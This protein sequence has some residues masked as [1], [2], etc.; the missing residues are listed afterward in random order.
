VGTHGYDVLVPNPGVNSFNSGT[1]PFGNLPTAPIDARFSQVSQLNSNGVSNFAGLITS[2]TR[3]FG[4][5]FQGSLN[6][7]YSHALD[8]I[9]SLPGTPYNLLQSITGQINPFNLRQLN[10]SNS[11][12]DTR[13]NLTA[14]YL[15][16]LPYKFQNK[17]VEAALGG[18]QFGGTVFARTGLPWSAITSNPA[19]LQGSSSA[20]L[21]AYFTGG[22]LG[23]CNTPGDVQFGQTGYSATT[24]NFCAVSPADAGLPGGPTNSNF[25]AAGTEPGFGNVARNSFRGPKY[26]NTDFNVTKN[27]KITE[28]VNFALGANMF[29]VLNHPNFALPNNN[30]SSPVFGTITNTVAPPTTPYGAF[31]P[32][33]I[34][35]RLIQVTSKISF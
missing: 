35:G 22:S 19:I 3:R 30:I 33:G 25:L 32:A 1:T 31:Q 23:S 20:P 13:H 2:I 12:S 24:T 27:F 17:F 7:T 10:Y 4:Y 8:D 16:E 6:Y 18:W 5:G 26:F 28:R 29:N 34:T 15:W 14:N 21:L 9:T 11:D